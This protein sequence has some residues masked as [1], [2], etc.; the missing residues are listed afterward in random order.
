MFFVVWL[1]P[2]DS[3]GNKCSTWC[4]D[5]FHIVMPTQVGIHVFPLC[6]QRKR[7]WPAFA[8]HDEEA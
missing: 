1:L 5:R 2:K 3:L 8:G 6:W 7:G 4:N